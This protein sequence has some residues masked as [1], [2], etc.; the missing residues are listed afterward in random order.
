MLSF[1][2]DPFKNIYLDITSLEPT[3]RF[4]IAHYWNYVSVAISSQTTSLLPH[5]RPPPLYKLANTWIY[6]SNMIA[7]WQLTVDLDFLLLR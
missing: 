3:A 6:L 5:P 2:S 1:P 7:K 4:L